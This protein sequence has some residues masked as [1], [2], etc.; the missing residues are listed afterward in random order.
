MRNTTS[1]T[2]F[3]IAYGGDIFH[4][5]EL[6]PGGELTTCQPTVEQ[7]DTEELMNARLTALGHPIEE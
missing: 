2:I 4:H 1:N 5:G 7:F 3:F 6:L